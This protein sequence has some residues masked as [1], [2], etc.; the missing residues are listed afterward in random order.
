MTTPR[1]RALN[2]LEKFALR[3]DEHLS[4]IASD[5]GHSSSAHW[6]HEVRNWL[7]QMQEELPH[8]GK[9]TAT[10]WQARIDA[11]RATLGE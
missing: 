4:K 10:Q 6:K 7:R 3:M 1:K 2:R 8:V 9:K 5:R 11:C